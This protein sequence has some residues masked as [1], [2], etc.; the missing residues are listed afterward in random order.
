MLRGRSIHNKVLREL[1]L[2]NYLASN[3]SQVKHLSAMDRRKMISLTQAKGSKATHHLRR[4]EH[5]VPQ[6]AETLPASH[7]INEQEERFT[8]SEK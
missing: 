4:V 7:L 2:R 3:F 8:L 5:L 6:L 1:N